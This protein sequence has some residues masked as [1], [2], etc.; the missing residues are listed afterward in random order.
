MQSGQCCCTLSWQAFL[1]VCQ[2]F[3]M[4]AMMRPQSQKHASMQQKHTH[5]APRNVEGMPG[6][7]AHTLGQAV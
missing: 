7:Q 4:N 6:N 2:G 5:R 3:Q 1:E